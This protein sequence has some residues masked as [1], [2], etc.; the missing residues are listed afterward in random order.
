MFRRPAGVVM[1]GGT[2]RSFVQPGANRGLSIARMHTIP[3][4]FPRFPFF[5]GVSR[6]SGIARLF[7]KE[8]TRYPSHPLPSAPCNTHMKMPPSLGALYQ[9]NR[10]VGHF[11]ETPRP[12]VLSL[13][14]KPKLTNF[15][16]LL[17]LFYYP[18]AF[19]RSRSCR[20]KKPS[21]FVGGQVRGE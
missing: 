3:L 2:M 4:A 15:F 21:G 10:S 5:Q 7:G 17:P 13:P 1:S 11:N 19:Y 6:E 18:F 8:H 20:Q 16:F 14:P 12:R 9:E